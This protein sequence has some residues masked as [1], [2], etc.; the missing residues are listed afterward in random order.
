MLSS[1]LILVTGAS[2]GIGRSV[3]QVLTREGAKVVATGR[4]VAA[5][6]ELKSSGGC[7]DFVVAD[8]AEAGECE[9]VVTSAAETLGGITGVV[10]CAG[11]LK[12][13]AMGSIGLDNYMFNFQLNVQ[14]VFEIMEHSI[15]HLRKAGVSSSPSI[16]NMSSVTGKQSFGG[17]ASYCASKAAVDQLTRCAAVDLAPDGI[18]VNAVNPGVIVTGIHQ[19]AGLDDEAYAAFLKRCIEI[20]H[21]I[22]KSLGRVGNPEEVADLVSFLVSDKAKFIT[23]E[24]IAIDGGRQCMGAR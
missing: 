4:N 2:S 13:G 21:P 12:G 7:Y 18:R 17:V 8:L 9:R 10:N 24:C 14:T 15:P 20:T 19:T 22:S 5:L 11:V 1:K 16:I 23:G 6:N 3:A